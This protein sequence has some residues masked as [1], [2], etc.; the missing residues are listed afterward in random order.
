MVVNVASTAHAMTQPGLGNRLENTLLLSQGRLDAW[1]EYCDSKAANILFA[2]A[3]AR[4]IDNRGVSQS[5]P[6]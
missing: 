3:L 6:D 1:S 2:T 5:H 4:R